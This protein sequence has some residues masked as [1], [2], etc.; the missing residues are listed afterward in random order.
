MQGGEGDSDYAAIE[1]LCC[2]RFSG[3]FMG[4]KMKTLAKT[5]L[6]DNFIFYISKFDVYQLKVRIWFNTWQIMGKY[7]IAVVMKYDSV[8]VDKMFNLMRV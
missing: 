5:E 7:C 2:F 6:K 4:Y 8:S 1:V 3:V